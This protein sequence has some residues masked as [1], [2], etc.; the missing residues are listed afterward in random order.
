MG[1]ILQ[2]SIKIGK[3]QLGTNLNYA[4][5]QKLIIS[6]TIILSS[7]D[8]AV[9]WSGIRCSVANNTNEIFDGAASLK[10]TTDGTS[11]FASFSKAISMNLLSSLGLDFKFRYYLH[12][13]T[14][15]IG[16]INVLLIDNTGKYFIS[17]AKSV[18]LQGKWEMWYPTTW[19]DSGG[20]NWANIVTCQIRIN[21]TTSQTPIVSFD[22]MDYRPVNKK[23]CLIMFDDGNLTDYTVAYPILRA[24]KMVATSY[25]VSALRS[26][27]YMTDSQMIE[28]NNAGWCIGNHTQHH[29]LDFN[30]T[31]AEYEA[32]IEHCRAYL[33]NIGLTRASRHVGYTG[34]GWSQ[35]AE[36]ACR[37]WGALTG[38]A[39]YVLIHNFY[40]IGWPY[41]SLNIK[42]PNLAESTA[43]TKAYIDQA[44]RL[45]A[46]PMLVWHKLAQNPVGSESSLPKFIEIIDY[47][48]SLGLQTLTIDEYYRLYYAPITVHHK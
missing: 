31:Q 16:S 37:N 7:F 26:A 42:S 1:L 39:G 28:L 20:A 3:V 19:T 40:E 41:T 13:T 21:Y 25:F 6:P 36:D 9:G 14:S 15:T 46:T 27:D 30:Y 32:Q 44:L 48:E 17:N 8:T 12:T 47:I 11:T 34:A 4:L 33:D 23:A 24:K 18:N 35:V 5:P 29:P 43:I 10:V 22:L 38:R 2:N 45:G